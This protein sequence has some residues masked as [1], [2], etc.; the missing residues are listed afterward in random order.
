M[1]IKV[2]IQRY[3]IE[4]NMSKRL[5]A[6]KCGISESYIGRIENEG[7]VPSHI[8][9]SKISAALKTCPHKIIDYCNDCPVYPDCIKWK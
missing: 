3:R 5:L 7:H 4:A 8:I 1:R 9:I 2:K 6:Q